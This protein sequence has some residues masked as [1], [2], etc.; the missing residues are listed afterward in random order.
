MMKKMLQC[1]SS[2]PWPPHSVKVTMMT[3]IQKDN[4][5][6]DGNYDNVDNDKNAISDGCNTVGWGIV[7]FPELNLWCGSGERTPAIGWVKEPD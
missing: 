5:D 1:R 2:S 3:K 6:M 7:R 4:G